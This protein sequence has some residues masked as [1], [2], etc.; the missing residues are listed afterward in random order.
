M[1]QSELNRVSVAAQIRIED[2][3][4]IKERG[5]QVI[6]NNRP[7]GEVKSQ[8]TSDQV[9]IE[10][11]ATGLT[12]FYIPISPSGIT[13]ENIDDTIGVLETTSG[14]VLAYCRTGNRSGVIMEALKNDL[15]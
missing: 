1:E 11:E 12:Y 13:Q 2:V 14:P 15:S 4:L 3:R 10:A 5:Y 7:D 9:R 8:P 6:I